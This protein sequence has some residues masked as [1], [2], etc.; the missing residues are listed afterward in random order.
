MGQNDSLATGLCPEGGQHSHPSA[1]HGK[2]MQHTPRACRQD[3]TQVN[4][5]H[6]ITRRSLYRMQEQRA[7][8]NNHF[9]YHSV[10][11]LL[12]WVDSAPKHITTPGRPTNTA[13]D[14]LAGLCHSYNSLLLTPR[15][16]NCQG[17]VPT[18]AQRARP[19][20]V[21]E[22]LMPARSKLTAT[23][24][25]QGPR[26]KHGRPQSKRM[27]VVGSLPLISLS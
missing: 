27:L 9:D 24:L 8:E 7:S 22:L 14:V 25:P 17:F 13:A 12:H 19:G 20:M 10:H 1:T 23:P 5:H 15:Q 11:Q 3:N 21:S 6:G 2:Y 16:D 26:G 4:S 18:T